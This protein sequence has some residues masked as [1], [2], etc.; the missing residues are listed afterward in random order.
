MSAPDPMVDIATLTARVLAAAIEWC[1]ANPSGFGEIFSD[2]LRPLREAVA[3]FQ[4]AC[5]PRPLSW[6]Q[7]PAGW[8]VQAP[9][10][11]WYRVDRTKLLHP[12]VQLVTM[13]GKEWTR[14]PNGPVTARP[15][16]PNPTDAALAALG[17]PE[18][19]ED[20]P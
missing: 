14:D 13:L 18:V 11:K 20:G 16:V 1:E 5:K 8:E 2:E 6:G 9:D 15:G 4:A 12:G 3:N 10:G 19:L 17:W 7:V